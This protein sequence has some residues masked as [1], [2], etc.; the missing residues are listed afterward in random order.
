MNNFHSMCIEFCVFDERTNFIT[1]YSVSNSASLTIAESYFRIPKCKL[2]YKMPIWPGL[3]CKNTVNSQPR[4]QKILF[5]WLQQL[6]LLVRLRQP[7]H[8]RTQ[9]ILFLC[10]QQLV[11]LVR[12][13]QALH[14]RTQKI[15]FL[16]WFRQHLILLL[17]SWT[18]WLSFHPVPLIILR[19]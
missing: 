18:T 15:L 13:R 6:V 19:C 5:L 2:K 14:L 11:L 3:S 9:K 1:E 12:L 10:L 8:L 17:R 4:P 16:S 7:L